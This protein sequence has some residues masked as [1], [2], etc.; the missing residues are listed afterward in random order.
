MKNLFL[1]VLTVLSFSTS[2]AQWGKDKKINGN[3]NMTT[4]TRTTSSYD[5]ISCAGSFDYVLIAGTE[6]NITLE[7]EENLLEYIITEVKDN[8]LIIKTENNIY[9]NC[10]RN[11]LNIHY[12][13]VDVQKYA[14]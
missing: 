9:L 14:A 13:T 1:S 3:G 8:K 6:G 4:I 7:G 12:V 2:Q 10:S 5:G 11:K